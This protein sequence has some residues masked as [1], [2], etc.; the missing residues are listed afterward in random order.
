METLSRGRHPAKNEISRVGSNPACLLVLWKEKRGTQA[1]RAGGMRTLVKGGH[2]QDKK[3]GQGLHEPSV[4]VANTRDSQL[5]R[6]ATQRKG[7][8]PGVGQHRG[9]VKLLS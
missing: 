7:L 1:Q 3:R 9:R 6:G 8:S 5:R 2:L 4:T